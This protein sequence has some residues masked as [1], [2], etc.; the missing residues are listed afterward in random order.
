MCFALWNFS[1]FV[2]FSS[3]WG[4]AFCSVLAKSS[5]VAPT[6]TTLSPP[7]PATFASFFSSFFFFCSFFCASSFS[8]PRVRTLT[9]PIIL[10]LRPLI[11]QLLLQFWSLEEDRK[12]LGL[13]SWLL[14]FPRL[15][16]YL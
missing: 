6:T 14:L 13:P 16:F 12:C 11:G 8:T 2:F 1:F 7:L 15:E 5:S 10:L 9:F 4:S 3:A